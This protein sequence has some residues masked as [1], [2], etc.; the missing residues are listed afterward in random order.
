MI[1]DIFWFFIFIL[2][3]LTFNLGLYGTQG[4]TPLLLKNVSFT[5]QTALA[6]TF[7]L[8]VNC[9]LLYLDRQFNNSLFFIQITIPQHAA[10]LLQFYIIYTVFLIVLGFMCGFLIKKFIK[11]YH[12]DRKYDLLKID[13]PWYYLF[14]GYN[15]LKEPKSILI[16]A[17]VEL[18]DN[19]YMYTGLLDSYHF[20]HMGNLDRLVLNTVSRYTVRDNISHF[21]S[22]EN[23]IFILKYAEIKCL[24]I[25]YITD[26]LEES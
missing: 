12:L 16:V 15:W 19:R 26:E 1:F 23:G 13:S 10:F 24:N 18:A 5:H 14:E 20:D 25:D 8:I 17:Q 6:F 21:L 4:S 11:A 2:P 22:Q 9:S 3:R 7:A